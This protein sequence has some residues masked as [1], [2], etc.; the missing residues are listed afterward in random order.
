MAW[1]VTAVSGPGT[2][3]VPAIP[4]VRPTVTTLPRPGGAEAVIPDGSRVCLF[5][6]LSLC[7]VG[8]LDL[9]VDVC[10]EGGAGGV[11]AGNGVYG[12]VRSLALSG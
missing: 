9:F 7:C 11:G 3:T 8:L 10:T 2:G 4:G 5:V 12:G 1:T 6:G